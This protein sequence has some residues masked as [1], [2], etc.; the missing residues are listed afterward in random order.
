MQNIIR[1]PHCGLNDLRAR[2]LKDL[3]REYSAILLARTEVV[4]GLRLA[5]VR[6]VHHPRA[7]DYV[8]QR[9]AFLRLEREFVHRV[10]AD[11][12]ESF[13]CDTIID[14]HTHPFCRSRVAFSGVDDRDEQDFARF[15]RERFDGL[16][17][18]SIV[19][20]QEEYSARMWDI[21]EGTPT[22]S[23]AL[24]RTQTVGEG[25]P[26][27]DQG[28]RSDS[29]RKSGDGLNQAIFDRAVRA[30]GLGAM[31]KIASDQTITVVGVGGLGSIVAEHLVHMGFQRIVLVDPDHIELSNLNRI[32]GAYHEDAEAKRPKVEVV[33]R[34]LTRIN[35]EAL[36]AARQCDVREPSL[37]PLIASSDWLIVATDNHT[38]RHFAQRASL[39]YFVP[40]ISVGVNITV[41]GSSV[42][43]MSGE[44]ITARVGDNLCLNCL[45]RINHIKLAS[46]DHPEGTVRD[47]LFKRGY[48]QG[49]DVKEPAV[50]TLNSILASLAVDVLV[51]Q[52][53]ERQRHVPVL[54][55]ES[56]AAVATYEDSDSLERRNMDCY[57]C[58]VVE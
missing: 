23:A 26:S 24:V 16:S 7:V 53:T 5:T 22:Q 46:E 28:P 44:V 30:L 29:D 54:V 36:V 25:I 11:L 35:P 15:L 9:G 39:R 8:D 4:G 43:D 42:V 31:R 48:V 45:G 52:Y 6:K 19:L 40:L 18:G 20:S 57:S 32:V 49:A 34:H 33:A 37:A 2:L 50:K 58:N 14:V 55:H 21:V 47:E 38:S 41:E 27:S 13:E 10:L 1:F 56:N 51:N 17:Y 12:V 3:S